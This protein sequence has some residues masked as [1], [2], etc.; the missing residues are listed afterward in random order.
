MA[1]AF[2][3]HVVRDRTGKL[4]HESQLTP[5]LRTTAG[6]DWQAALMGKVS[7]QPVGAAYIALSA[8]TS[9]PS[10]SDTSL[11][12]EYTTLGL[13]RALGTY[14][15]T[16]GA[17]SYTISFTFTATGPA[18]VAKTALFNATGPPVAGTMPF[19]S[20][21][22]NPVQLSTGDVDTQITTVSI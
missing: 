16:A 5:N 6:I 18:V 22:T 17:S 1:R 7:G 21:E 12:S 19:E 3:T 2:F 10:V 4:K 8:D 20:L 15:H 9:A 14:A 11:P 13:S